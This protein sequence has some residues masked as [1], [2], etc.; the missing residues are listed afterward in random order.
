MRPKL[1]LPLLSAGA[2]AACAQ[3]S[4]RDIDKDKDTA[5]VAKTSLRALLGGSDVDVVGV[6]VDPDDGQR[7]V[8]DATAGLY[9]IDGDRAELIAPT[10]ELIGEDAVPQS[11]FT[12]VV[13]LGGG[14]FAMTALNDGF[15]YDHGKKQFERYFCY[16]PGSIIDEFDPVPVVQL[17]QSVTYDWARDQLFAQPQTFQRSPANDPE[18][19]EVGRFDIQGGEGYDWIDLGDPDFVA[20]GIA[21]DAGGAL[22]LGE[23][24]TLYRLDLETSDFDRAMDLA[25]HGV[26]HV[27]GLAIVDDRAL[28][29]DA[30]TD[31]L[32]EIRL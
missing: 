19:A 9:R 28:V 32:F 5:L 11:D 29:V 26:K 2:L 7:Y 13:A 4:P 24:R 3:P 23:G 10:Y 8:L 16:V 25:Q 12:D 18:R 15:L 14:R 1:L 31:E 22:I 30:E 21:I 20:G 6:T 27:G 17:T